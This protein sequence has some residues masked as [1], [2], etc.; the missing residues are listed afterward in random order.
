MFIKLHEI[1]HGV[2]RKCEKSDRVFM[3]NA[4]TVVYMCSGSSHVGDCRSSGALLF[5]SSGGRVECWESV[6]EVMERIA[7]AEKRFSEAS[8]VINQIRREEAR[9]E[10]WGRKP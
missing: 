2:D 10:S 3:V 7:E 9:E 1:R 4:N 6:S 8:S 5:F